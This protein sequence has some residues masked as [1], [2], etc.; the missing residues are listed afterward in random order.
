MKFNE[1]DGTYFEQFL[2]IQ[3]PQLVLRSYAPVTEIPDSKPTVAE[4]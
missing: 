4:S 3:P 2:P 1:F